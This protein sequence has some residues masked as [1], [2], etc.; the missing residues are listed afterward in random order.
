M[1]VYVCVCL[2]VCVLCFCVAVEGVDLCGCI[3]VCMGCCGCVDMCV[4]VDVCGWMWEDV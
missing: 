2:C 4:F 3:D 1:S